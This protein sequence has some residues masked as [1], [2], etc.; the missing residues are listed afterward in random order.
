MM[1]LA[2]PFFQVLH[3]MHANIYVCISHSLPQW[4]KM[5][6]PMAGVTTHW[7]IPLMFAYP[8]VWIGTFVTF[9]GSMVLGIDVDGA[10][11][12]IGQTMFD[13]PFWSAMQVL[14]L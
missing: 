5:R 6:P 4:A 1:L 10:F 3:I 8:T 12:W 9:Y 14:T 7:T 13:D 2:L 11:E